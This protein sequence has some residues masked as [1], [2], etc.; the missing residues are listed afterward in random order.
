[1]E[2]VG[3]DTTVDPKR[4]SLLRNGAESYL[5]EPY[6]DTV[7]EKW[8]GWRPMTWDGKPLIGPSPRWSNVFIAAGHNMLGLSM[9]PATGKLIREMIDGETPHIDAEP[10]SP[11][12]FG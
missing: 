12:R 6:G 1:M 11:Q 2:F 7:E 8:Y 5:Q 3:Y 4:L 9:A 10:Y